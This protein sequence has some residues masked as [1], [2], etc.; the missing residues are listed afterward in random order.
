MKKF[1]LLLLI[2]CLAAGS[3]AQAQTITYHKK[4]ATLKDLLKVVAKQAGY[5]HIFKGEIVQRVKRVDISVKN[6]TL[7]EVLDEF[8]KDQPLT[9]TIVGLM[10]SISPKEPLPSEL[11]TLS[12]RITNEANETLPGVTITVAG[13]N[14]SVAVNDDGEFLFPD[15]SKT[16][17]LVI[18]SVSY[19]DTAVRLR[20]Q[21]VLQ[22]Q[23][24]AKIRELSEVSVST[25]YQNLA[26]MEIGRASC[27]ERV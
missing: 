7:R 17:S 26:Y 20:G 13:T 24:R 27:R 18:T 1:I 15:L 22:L 2:A 25:G 6:G 23:L 19:V 9:Y 11:Y 4:N 3:S 12:G 5:G 21:S 16:D 14:R 8:F 10:I